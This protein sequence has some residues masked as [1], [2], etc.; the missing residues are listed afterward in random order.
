M[1]RR[2]CAVALWCILFCWTCL[3]VAQS[4]EGPT[5]ILSPPVQRVAESVQHLVDETECTCSHVRQSK[6]WAIWPGHTVEKWM[7]NARWTETGMK[8]PAYTPGR[9]WPHP[10]NNNPPPQ[11]NYEHLRGWLDK[12]MRGAWVQY[13]IE[14][15]NWAGDTSASTFTSR[16]Q[17]RSANTSFRFDQL[18]AW[19][20]ANYPHLRFGTYAAISPYSSGRFD[21]AWAKRLRGLL[22]EDSLRQS[23]QEEWLLAVEQGW[24]QFKHSRTC[25]DFILI[26]FF[27]HQMLLKVHPNEPRYPQQSNGRRWWKDG[28]EKVVT[29]MRIQWA[30]RKCRQMWPGPDQRVFAVAF[31][32]FDFSA[33]GSPQP[34]IDHWLDMLDTIYA[35]C[36][37]VEFFSID[38]FQWSPE[39]VEAT[40]KW[41]ADHQTK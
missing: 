35:E 40:E 3:L 11:P 7:K 15:R 2:F 28:Q 41:I 26:P 33:D 38:P 31:P 24:E 18:L 29:R 22:N 19:S 6:P 9:L 1:S 34:D 10:Q 17:L 4:P 12:E 37:G 8:R 5:P 25:A 32:T 13:D 27:P 20:K 36:D 30:V 23:D 21:D 14:H 16:D 39:L